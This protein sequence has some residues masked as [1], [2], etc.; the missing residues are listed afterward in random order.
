MVVAPRLL[1]VGGEVQGVVQLGE[2]GGRLLRRRRAGGQ[3]T[4]KAILESQIRTGNIVIAEAFNL[5][6]RT[7]LAMPAHTSPIGALNPPSP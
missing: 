7:G 4:A 6:L 1:L 2:P 3:A 5:R